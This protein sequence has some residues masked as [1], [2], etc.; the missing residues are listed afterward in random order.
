MGV[1]GD[2]AEGGG[3]QVVSTYSADDLS[4]SLSRVQIERADIAHVVAAWGGP[5]EWDGWQGGFLL[6]MR[7]GGYVYVTGWCDYTG[8][9]CQDGAEVTAYAQEPPLE[10]LGAQFEWDRDPADLNKWARQGNS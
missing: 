5:E 1:D 7:T 6:H 4:E 9:G 10:S 8:W 2:G 3:G